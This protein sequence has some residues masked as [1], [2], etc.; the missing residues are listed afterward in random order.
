MVF[1]KQNGYCF[2]R[3]FLNTL[4][5]IKNLWQLEKT[6]RMEVYCSI[7]LIPLIF[8]MPIPDLLRMMLLLLLFLLFVVEA[9][10]SAIEAV[11]DRISLEFH[12]KS[13][14]AKD[15]GSAAVGMVIFMNVLS[16][17]Y[18]VCIQIL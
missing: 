18:A 9:I 3:A 10:N 11:V 1:E 4:N 14:L 6:F 17:I 5:G 16:W 12:E 15:M 2:K 8:I 13:G 7:L